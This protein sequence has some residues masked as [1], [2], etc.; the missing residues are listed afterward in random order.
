M[1]MSAKSGTLLITGGSSSTVQVRS[2]GFEPAAVIFY[3][4]GRTESSNTA[5]TA[6]YNYGQG[7]A[8]PTTVCRNP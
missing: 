5:G 3:W 7:F 8:T 2:L 1:T 4:S 6:N